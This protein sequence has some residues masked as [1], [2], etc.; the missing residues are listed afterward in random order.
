[1]TVISSYA[2]NLLETSYYLCG[3]NFKEEVN[4]RDG[5]IYRK[6]EFIWRSG[7]YRGE[8]QPSALYRTPPRDR[9]FLVY[10]HSSKEVKPWQTRVLRLAGYDHIWGTNT[11]DSRYV[12]AIPLGVGNDSGESPAHEF[13]GPVDPIVN[14][15]QEERSTEFTNSIYAN[16]NVDNSPS[17]RTLARF[18]IN[19]Q[20]SFVVPTYTPNGRWN[21]LL[22]SRKS[23]FVLCPRGVGVE[24]H[25]MWETLMLG[26]IPVV[27]EHPF[28][29]PFVKALPILTVDSWSRLLE[30]QWLE[31]RFYE[32]EGRD[33]DPELLD[34]RYWLPKT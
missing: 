20:M 6:V 27:E 9:H 17:R 28:L 16:F 10:G 31:E 32:L 2:T 34:V 29:A 7:T 33:Y 25:R 19:S 18:L 14:A 8:H 24:T 1:M 30:P 11:K 26:S 23:N 13:M 21:A 12:T 3:D 22:E 5:W 15:I 4:R